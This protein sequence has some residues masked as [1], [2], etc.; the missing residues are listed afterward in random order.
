MGVPTAPKLTG[1]DWMINPTITAAIAGKPIASNSGATTA[2][3][4]PKPEAPSMKLPKSQPMMMACTRLSEEIWSK[5]ALMRFIAPDTV[6][7]DKR[8]RAPKTI[9]RSVAATTTPSTVAAARA[10]GV[11]C[12]VS[13]AT[14]TAVR[15][16]TGMVYF[17]GQRNPA[18]RMPA[19]RIG[20]IANKL[21]TNRLST[22]RT[23]FRFGPQGNRWCAECE[24]NVVVNE[25]A[26]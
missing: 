24:E 18:S 7:V 11:I 17:A 15:K 5:P 8:S 3:G 9:Y 13:Q 1:V 4:V 20:V 22:S 14:T 25:L 26:Y 23:S 16:L 19:T 10:V 6:T 21:R 2:A 12:Q